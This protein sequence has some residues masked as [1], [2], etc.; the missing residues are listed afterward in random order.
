MRAEQWLMLGVV[1]IGSYAVYRMIANDPP[2]P[3][4]SVEHAPAAPG[5]IPEGISVVK[6]PSDLKKNQWY[7]GRFEGM[8]GDAGAVA[9]LLGTLGFGGFDSGDAA[10]YPTA[11]S[12]RA[13][14]IPEWAL[15][16]AGAGTRWFYAP[17]YGPAQ[18]TAFPSNTNVIYVARS[19][20]A[21][22]PP[23]PADP[24][25]PITFKP[26]GGGLGT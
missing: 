15:S 8:S 18:A 12:A 2:P 6:T 13:G 9:A 26:Q 21:P 1:G 16:G 4:P 25:G 10:I 23:P 20:T 24:S 7:K 17:W 11:D 19:P 3:S 14:G 5:A 22:S